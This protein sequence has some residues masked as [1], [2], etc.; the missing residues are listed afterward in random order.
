MTLAKRARLFALTAA[1]T[2]AAFSLPASAQEIS[3]SHLK[4]ARAAI[5][6]IAATDDFDN[7]LP[8][9]A[10]TLKAE[11][12]QQSPNMVDLINAT[13]DEKAL[14]L[15]S[16]RADLENE[17]AHAYARVFSEEDL[18]NITEFYNSPT[19]QK[20]LADGPIVTREVLRAASVWRRGIERD[21]SNSVTEQLEAATNAQA[22]SGNEAESGQ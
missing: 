20:L 18:N 8:L 13:V 19:G 16:R 2:F 7:Y 11:L 21:L 12:I 9:A 22:P 14:D 1:M 6:A 15:A 5:D 10:Q 3:E 4:A 17:A